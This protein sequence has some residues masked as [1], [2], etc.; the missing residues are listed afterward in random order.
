LPCRTPLLGEPLPYPSREAY[1]YLCQALGAIWRCAPAQTGIALAAEQPLQAGTPA[2]GR[3]ALIHPCLDQI[4]LH[5]PEMAAYPN[6]GTGQPSQENLHV[7]CQQE[8]A[9]Y[10]WLALNWG[11]N[12]L[13]FAPGGSHWIIQKLMPFD[14]PSPTGSGFIWDSQFKPQD[15]VSSHA[16]L[17]SIHGHT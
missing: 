15:V 11:Y 17:A 9:N 13:L 14:P 3:G 1:D 2:A 8:R 10:P 5:A 12:S 7:V 4:H 6:F 16:R